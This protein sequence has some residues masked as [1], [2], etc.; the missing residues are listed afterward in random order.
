MQFDHIQPLLKRVEASLTALDRVFDVGDELPSDKLLSVISLRKTNQEIKKV[1]PLLLAKF[2]YGTHKQKVINQ[3][4]PE[5]TFHM[6]IDEAHNILSTQSN[7]ER[8][9]VGKT[10][11]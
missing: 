7:R 11:D 4:P 8:V 1:L 2:Y 3:S 6:I 10:I 5:Q 9:K